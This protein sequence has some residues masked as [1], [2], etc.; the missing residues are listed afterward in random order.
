MTDEEKKE[1]E[2]LKSLLYTG[3]ISQYG[4]RKLIDIIEKQSKEIE[5]LKDKI[6]TFKIEDENIYLQFGE[7]TE[8][9]R[10]QDKIKAMLENEI[11]NI[12][13]FECVAKEDVQSLLEKE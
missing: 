4:K 7:I 6:K 1:Y 13:G 9:K 2:E 3:T 8:K 12:S 10:W 5:E 11:I